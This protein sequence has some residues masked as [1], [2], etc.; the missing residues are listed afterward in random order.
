[1][2]GTIRQRGT[3]WTWQHPIG[4]VGGKRPVRHRHREAEEGAVQVALT[5][6][7]GK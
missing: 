3:T 2:K 5:D 1:M 6:S 7:L 4:T